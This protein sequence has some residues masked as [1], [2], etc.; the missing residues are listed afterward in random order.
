LAIPKILALGL[1]LTGALSLPPLEFPQRL[2][3]ALFDLW[4]RL[5]PPRAP[6]DIL[7]VK[8]YGAES[9]AALLDTAVWQ[10][11]RLVVTTLADKPQLMSRRGQVLGP[12]AVATS[13]MPIL[14]ETAWRRGGY[15]WTR[16]DLDGVVR[17]ERPSIGD[18]SPTPS[19]ALAA[20]GTLAAAVHAEP[21]P[22]AA[23]GVGSAATDPF[24]RRWLRFFG[25][26][27]F[28]PIALEKVS[29]E[30]NALTDK[31]VIAGSADAPR[32]DTPI[33]P[34]TPAELTAHTLAGYLTGQF[35]ATTRWLDAA[36]WLLAV[37][38]IAG[39]VVKP[40]D[41]AWAFGV[42][43]GAAA[44]LLTAA[45]AAFVAGGVWIP[46]AAPALLVLALS[47]LAVAKKS[48]KSTRPRN[49]AAGGETLADARE[50]T[51]QG[52]L[53]Q[54]WA[55]YRKL[56]MRQ[57]LLAEIYELAD[58]L[59]RRG[60][61]R[62]AADLFH[63]IAQADA[64]FRDV[65]RRLVAAA[66]RPEKPPPD[67]DA[68]AK[69]GR[70]QILGLIGSG[71]MGVVYLGRDPA[72]NRI[73]A[74]KAIHFDKE[75]DPAYADEARGRFVR[76]AETAG[77][78]GHPSIVTIHDVG[79]E[80]GIAYIAMEYVCGS[81]LSN[82][83]EPRNLLPVPLVLELVARA[84]DALGYAHSQNVVH[85]DIKP[86]NIMYDS[87]T[88]SL[89]ITDFGIARLMDVSRTRTGIVLGTPS[90][91]SPEQLQGENVNGHTDL[92]AL[93]VSLYQ[94]L[95]GHLPFRGTSMTQLM[96]VIT[97]EPHMPVTA[98]RADLPPM[99]DDIMDRALAKQPAERFSTGG[100]MARALRAVPAASGA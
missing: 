72:I 36:G 70:Y 37:L 7:V 2:D 16:A 67:I 58:A 100:E 48:E 10:S 4:T 55:V 30:P 81:H 1:L 86:A 39:I 64:T 97:N 80:D 84:A 45:A 53:E 63:R 19:L 90:Y 62:L 49:V 83:A 44:G 46:V 78:L 29:G 68:P 35:V 79:E 69:L 61:D 22:P 13:A 85:R 23:I 28:V 89:K 66:A 47:G 65:T 6:G 33:G 32:Y 8:L 98:T 34:L 27:A 88:D 21:H 57:D 38:C 71:A 60:E 25:A 51:A 24:G 43:A 42:P 56:P 14:R 99:L 9:H 92:F 3:R 54:S 95:T 96:F 26:D 73:V 11:A 93:G 94:L 75:F 40:L 52:A 41:R 77:R 12:V 87:A 91:M 31:I 17:F 20:A 5:G 82:H 74:I 15:L 76:E 59:G 18:V 50:L